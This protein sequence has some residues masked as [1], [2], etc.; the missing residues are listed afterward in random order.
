MA[1]WFR[2]AGQRA[3]ADLCVATPQVAPQGHIM[4]C[5]SAAAAAIVPMA[6]PTYVRRRLVKRSRR[7]IPFR[8]TE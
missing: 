1:G 6:T 5:G 7:I 2:D 3:R 4:T 8:V